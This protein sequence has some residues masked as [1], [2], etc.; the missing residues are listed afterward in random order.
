MSSDNNEDQI[1]DHLHSN[2]WDPDGYC[3][4]CLSYFKNCDYCPVCRAEHLKGD[5][6]EMFED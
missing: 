4:D 1:R 2:D 6:V 3:K 5:N